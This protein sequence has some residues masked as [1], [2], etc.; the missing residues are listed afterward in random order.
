MVTQG[1]KGDFRM[2]N[3]AC[4][5]KKNEDRPRRGTKFVYGTRYDILGKFWILRKYLGGF[6]V[7][8]W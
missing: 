2:R 8:C 3:K 6:V 5:T 1:A 7:A 4:P